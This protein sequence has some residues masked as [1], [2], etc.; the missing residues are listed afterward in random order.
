M[1][2]KG[3]QKVNVICIGHFMFILAPLPPGAQ[4]IRRVRVNQDLTVSVLTNQFD[5]RRTF[6]LS[7]LQSTSHGQDP[8]RQLLPGLCTVG[9]L[10]LHVMP[11]PAPV[12]C[13]PTV[14]HP[15]TNQEPP[16]IFQG[17]AC[18]FE[19]FQIAGRGKYVLLLPPCPWRKLYHP[20][21]LFWLL[22]YD[23]E[24]IDDLAVDVV[25]RLNLGQLLG[26]EYTARS[27]VGFKVDLVRRYVADYPVSY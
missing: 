23:S 11:P 14:G 6:D 20:G 26:E 22:P 1:S 17:I 21:Q 16:G 7:V 15:E 2:V 18:G 4:N 27:K 5:S 13:S 10:T 8:R 3:I 9:T 24:Q 19:V 25:D 12:G